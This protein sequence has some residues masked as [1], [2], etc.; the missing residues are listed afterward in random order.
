MAMTQYNQIST[1]DQ[2]RDKLDQLNFNG[3]IDRAALMLRHHGGHTS[4]FFLVC[5]DPDGEWLF[6]ADPGDTGE[7]KGHRLAGLPSFTAIYLF[8]GD[9]PR[10]KKENR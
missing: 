9:V 5:T 6:L 7:W 8:V 10:D 3:G 4:L 2:L 1:I